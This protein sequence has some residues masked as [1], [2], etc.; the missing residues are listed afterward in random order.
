MYQYYNTSDSDADH[1]Y[2]ALNDLE[3]HLNDLEWPLND[4]LILYHCLWHEK[5]NLI[6]IILHVLAIFS[7][8]GHQNIELYN[9]PLQ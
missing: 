8:F 6:D 5:F 3:W 7:Y 2:R 4:L 1:H 9:N